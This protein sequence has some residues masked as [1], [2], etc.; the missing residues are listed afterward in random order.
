[1]N[2]DGGERRRITDTPNV[3]DSVPRW[4][5]DGT[6][7]AFGRAY[8]RENFRA[9]VWIVQAD[10]T[11]PRCL[12]GVSGN[13][14]YWSSDGSKLLFFAPVGSATEI[15]EMDSDGSRPRQLTRFGSEDL[16]AQVFSGQSTNRLRIEPDGDPEIYVMDSDGSRIAPLT[17]NDAE[18]GAPE[19][20]P[21]GQNIVFSSNRDGHFEIYMM[22]ADGSDPR[23]SRRH[24][25]KSTRSNR[26]GSRG[27]CPPPEAFLRT[28]LPANPRP[29]RIA[30]S[31]APVRSFPGFPETR[32][33]F[34]AG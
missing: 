23:D 29:A 11:H 5:P 21:D 33:V 28:R 3:W 20:S 8:P 7:I 19:W 9:E 13:G 4:S 6:K 17:K 27:S 16:L 24:D 25:P 15:F 32:R 10:G 2:A 1:M 18:D 31:S 30:I 34:G 26:I 14:P 12:G 22:K